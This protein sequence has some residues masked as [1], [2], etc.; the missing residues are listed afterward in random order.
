[1]GS[2]PEEIEAALKEVDPI[3][4]HWQ[5]CIQSEAP[6]HTV[7]LTQPIYLGVTEVT[8]ADYEKVMGMNPSHFAPTGMGKEAVAG[9]ETAGHPVE[10]VS[11]NDAAEYCVKLSQ[12]E[13]RKPFYFRAGETITPLDGTGY[14]LPSEA[15]WEFACRAGTATKYWI[16]DHDEDLV[17]AGWFG[18]I[19]GGQTHAAGELKANPFGL[20]DMHGNVWE[21]VQD[22]W[23]GSYYGQF[24]VKPAINPGSPFSVGSQRVLRGGHWSSPASAC[25]SSFRFANVPTDRYD[26][27]GFRVSLPVDA[28]QQALKS[29]AASSTP[30]AA[31]ERLEDYYARNRRAAEKLL[32]VGGEQSN[33]TIEI[34]QP[35]E[36]RTVSPGQTLPD[37]PFLV[38]SWSVKNAQV[39]TNDDLDVLAGLRHVLSLNLAAQGGLDAACVAKIASLQSPLNDLGIGHIQLKTSDLGQLPIMP[40]IHVLWISAEQVDDGWRFLKRFPALRKLMLYGAPVPDLRPLGEISQLRRLEISAWGQAPDAVQIGDIQSGNPQLRILFRV[41]GKLTLLGTDPATAAGRKLLEGGIIVSELRANGRIIPLS[42]DTIETANPFTLDV[43]VIPRGVALTAE[44]RGL[45]THVDLQNLTAEG[46]QEADALAQ[47]L[48]NRQ[49]MEILNLMDSDLTDAG[50]LQLQRLAGMRSL[51]IRGTKV[52]AEGSAAF[53]RAVPGCHLQTDSGDIPVDYLAIP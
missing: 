53:H 2:T 13:K 46:L 3:H 25:R 49:D 5:E 14:R 17:P 21:W 48:R 10:T 50:L 8:Q 34:T 39:V 11:W 51:N 42:I 16:G 26:F 40:H 43:K 30:P 7:I 35:F 1:M 12:Q 9:L 52:T 27:F 22:G 20:Y 37:V 47:V 36:W 6:Q 33:V 38:R 24:F 4:K 32:A 41:D 18:G 15:E 45:L 44:L 29:Q 28:V 23:D 31:A 19:S